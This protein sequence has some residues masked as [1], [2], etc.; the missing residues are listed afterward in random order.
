[1]CD[2]PGQRAR[3]R[4]PARFHAD[5]AR[6]GGFNQRGDWRRCEDILGDQALDHVFSENEAKQP[7][8]VRILRWHLERARER[9]AGLQPRDW[10]GMVIHGDF[11]P[12]NLRFTDGRLSG[13]LDFELAHWDHRV[14]DFALAWRGKYD[15]VVHG[16]EEESPLSPGERELIT[17]LLWAT[18]IDGACRHLAEGTRDDG[19]MI[20]KLQLRSPL[21]GLD[22]MEFIR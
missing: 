18:L 10:P 16:Y 4:L 3:G 11:A 8:E 17:P 9:I 15:E 13:I 22:S 19:W 1:M 20:R 7:E 2:V 14:G 21:M 5:L 12:W 6:L